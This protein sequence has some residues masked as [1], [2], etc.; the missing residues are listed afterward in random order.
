[1]LEKKNLE[2]NVPDDTLAENINS[3]SAL[4]ILSE[5]R[6]ST[7]FVLSQRHATLDLPTG[8]IISDIPRDS[9]FGRPLCGSRALGARIG[10]KGKGREK[11]GREGRG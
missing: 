6:S 10:W 3:P 11:V 7:K 9:A 2:L 1:M 5:S 4:Y 8:Q